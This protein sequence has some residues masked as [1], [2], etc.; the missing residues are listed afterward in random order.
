[1]SGKAVV[2]GFSP[3]YILGNY[4]WFTT[5]NPWAQA[6]NMQICVAAGVIYASICIAYKLFFEPSPKDP[7]AKEAKSSGDKKEKKKVDWVE[8]IH[9]GI[10]CLLSLAMF[11]GMGGAFLDVCLTRGFSECL[12]VHQSGKEKYNL[13]NGTTGF[14]F[15]VFAAS[16][17]YELFD[18]AFHFKKGY[19]LL[20]L[21]WWHHA[22][23]PFLCAVHALEHSSSAWTGSIANC[24]VHIFMYLHYCVAATGSKATFPLRSLITSLQLAQFAS[25]IGHITFLFFNSTKGYDRFPMTFLACYTIYSSYF[26][27]FIKFFIDSYCGKPAKSGKDA[28]KAAKKDE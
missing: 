20:L 4:D 9:M 12:D 11:L 23:V 10:L 3:K 13:M 7:T 6:Y 21:H 8:V 17:F 5:A 15:M 16:K 24:F 26:I 1:M 18:T 22:T 19:Q 28:K 14:W 27:L 25:V 2:A